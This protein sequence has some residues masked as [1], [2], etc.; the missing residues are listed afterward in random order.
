VNPVKPLLEWALLRADPAWRARGRI[1]GKA[2]ILAYH[3]IVPDDSTD[4]ADPALHLPQSRFA[5]QL[6]LLA[7]TCEVVPLGE[8]LAGRRSEGRPLVAITFDDAYCGA[9]RLGAPLLVDRRLPATYFVAPGRLG[10]Q[11]FWWDVIRGRDGTPLDSNAREHILTTLQGKEERARSWAQ[12]DG[13][14]GDVPAEGLTA[15]EQ[16]VDW[17]ANLAGIDLGSHSWSHPNLATLSGEE[18]E[19]ELRMPADWIASKAERAQAVIA[20]PYG[21]SSAAVH[22][23]ARKAGYVAGLDISGG[24]LGTNDPMGLPRLNVPG[25][26][27][28]Q[29]FALRLKGLLAGERSS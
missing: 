6:D 19:Q 24:W 21:K 3:N 27:S 13:T 9:V 15:S 8:V 11:S 25:G 5:S 29:G 1:R 26:L 12:A 7:R 2:L 28:I 20:Y 4:W 14:Q 16:D 23:A 18:L 22:D 17:L 10:G